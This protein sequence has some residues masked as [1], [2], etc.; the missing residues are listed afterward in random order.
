MEVGE[1][2]C[3]PASKQVRERYPSAVDE[4]EIV[5]CDDQ[6]ARSLHALPVVLGFQQKHPVR[7]ESGG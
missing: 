1:A 4:I 7:G 6:N 3:R 2:F 5:S